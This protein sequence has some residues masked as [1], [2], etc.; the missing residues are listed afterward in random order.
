MDRIIKTYGKI[1][2]LRP[3]GFWPGFIVG[4][5]YFSFI[6]RWFWSLY[7]LNAFGV[8]S[9]FYS[10]L[11][12]LFVF[13]LSVAGTA[14]FWGLCSFF[15]FKLNKNPKFYLIPLIT[16]GIFVLVEY[17]RAWGFG[18]LWMGSESLLGPHWTL[19]SPA[20]SFISWPFVLNISSV[21]GIYGID[22]LLAWIVGTIFLFVADKYTINS[23]KVLFN[24][25]LVVLIFFITIEL[26]SKNN[27]GMADTIKISLIQTKDEAMF[28]FSADEILD[29]YTKKLEALKEAANTVDGGVVIFP[30]SSNFSKTL[31]N[32]LDSNSAQSYFKKLSDKEFTIVDNNILPDE[33]SFKS[34]TLF[35]SSKN[36]VSGFYDKQLLTPAG[37][38]LPYVLK[39]LLF[40][41]GENTIIAENSGLK[42]G[43]HSDL[44]NHDNSKI[45]ILVC[46]DVVS[47]VISSQGQYDLLIFLQNLGAFN[48]SDA[49]E[50][51]FLSM[52]RFRA[53]EN[54]KYAVLASNFGRSYII[55]SNGQIEKST[56][57]TGYK[58]LTANVV[59]NKERTWYNKLGD[60]PILLLSLAIFGYRVLIAIAFPLRGPSR[61]IK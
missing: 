41:L 53:A 58:I 40:V 23:K 8:E 5:I 35:I 30:E 46:S 11:L 47:P 43:T 36:G 50:S 26:S 17:A 18:F 24:L 7:P 49:I 27:S 15:I 14:F 19:G 48:G 59:P 55:N 34:R 56:T 10:F 21:L 54:G 2:R 37:E 60:L 32:F 51:Q 44:L 1:V 12:I 20:Y 28:K 38:Y 16:A 25:G 31:L 57:E 9:G 3:S 4:L 42:T 39:F 45:K 13:T 52:L 61:V 33:E 29:N 22:F 6:F